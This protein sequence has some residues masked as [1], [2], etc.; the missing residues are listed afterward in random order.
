MGT[1]AEVR[2][3]GPRLFMIRRRTRMGKSRAQMAQMCRCSAGLLRMLE[4]DA[5][6]VTHPKIAARIAQAYRLG[7]TQAEMMLPPNYR[8]GDPDYDPDRYRQE[9][10]EW[11]D[12]S[13]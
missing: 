4:E 10:L 9:V 1:K 5:R 6:C 8:T 13:I 11:K 12:R 2:P 3:T 7:R